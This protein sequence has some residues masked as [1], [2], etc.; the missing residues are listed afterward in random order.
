MSS[1][2]VLFFALLTGLASLPLYA[3]DLNVP[4]FTGMTLPIGM[5]DGGTWFLLCVGIGSLIVTRRF[6]R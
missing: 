6:V 1:K 2:I 3:A 5:V 4:F